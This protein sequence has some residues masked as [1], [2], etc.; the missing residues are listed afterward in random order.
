MMITKLHAILRRPPSNPLFI[1]ILI[2]LALGI[3]ITTQVFAAPPAQGP[4][5]RPGSRPQNSNSPA[6]SIDIFPGGVT[7]LPGVVNCGYLVILENAAGNINN[8]A[9]WSDVVV[10]FC[11]IDAAHGN[12]VQMIAKGGA[13][14]SV[15]TVLAANNA[16]V[17]RSQTCTADGYVTTYSS[18]PN[19]FTLHSPCNFAPREVPESD[20]IILLGGG[21]GGVATWLT[22]QWSKAKR[23]R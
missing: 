21:F 4:G 17:V 18:A 10:F 8:Q 14:P 11:N 6:F 15:A 23:R 5:G 22:W 13:F 1:A 16:T 19:T 20:T 9:T 12:Q 7:N 2:A 3:A